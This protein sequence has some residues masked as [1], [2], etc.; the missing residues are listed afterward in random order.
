MPE[1]WYEFTQVEVLERAFWV[2]APSAAEARRLK[3][4]AGREGVPDYAGSP[5]SIRVV[6]RGRLIRD[7]YEIEMIES[8]AEEL[9]RW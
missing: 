8:R 2:K 5:S 4:Y 7:A 3:G 6:G 9:E 1:R